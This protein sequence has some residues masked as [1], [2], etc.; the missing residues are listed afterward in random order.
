[1]LAKMIPPLLAF[2]RMTTALAPRQLVVLGLE[3]IPRVCLIG[4]LSYKTAPMEVE[5][6]E[7]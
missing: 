2:S 4:P 1:M 6:E 3:L 7:P 5:S